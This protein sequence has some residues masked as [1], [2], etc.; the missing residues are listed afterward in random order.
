MTEVD[1]FPSFSDLQNT[2]SSKR[3]GESLQGSRQPTTQRSFARA[4]SLARTLTA[5]LLKEDNCQRRMPKQTRRAKR[6]HSSKPAAA[7]A[8]QT[9]P[10]PAV[11]NVLHGIAEGGQIS[12]KERIRISEM[13][14]NK[15]RLDGRDAKILLKWLIPNT[16]L[17]PVVSPKASA[18]TPRRSVS[19]SDDRTPTSESRPRRLSQRSR[20]DSPKLPWSGG[21]RQHGADGEDPMV[22]HT[23]WN[24]LFYNL[25]RSVDELYCMCETEESIDESHEAIRVLE[26][27]AEDF[28]ALIRRFHVER[29][30]DAAPPGIQPSGVAWELRKMLSPGTP[31][32]P[33]PS[34]PP[35]PNSSSKR[36]LS[37]GTPPLPSPS[38]RPSPSKLELRPAE[39][40]AAE[41]SGSD[42]GWVVA[43]SRNRRRAG[44]SD[45]PKSGRQQA[46]SPKRR[47]G[48]S[49]AR[50]P[51][52]IDTSRM[53]SPAEDSFNAHV[54]RI[55]RMSNASE[56]SYES[57]GS[58]GRSPSDDEPRTWADV[59]NVRGAL[60]NR[61]IHQRLS[62]Q[63]R[64]SPSKKSTLEER[65]AKV[66]ATLVHGMGGRAACGVQAQQRRKQQQAERDL[67]LRQ[68]NEHALQVMRCWCSVV[69]LS[70][71]L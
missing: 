3:A 20:K 68:Q 14:E 26:Q 52:T 23:L 48:A 58:L 27:C 13:L 38:P 51:P 70:V 43:R 59:C 2:N 55:R 10:G 9:E 71:A 60:R 44:A 1:W 7:P 35:L 21:S 17:S 25:N 4:P 24:Y 45:A 33:T 49:T 22:K 50:Q 19:P 53:A 32:L 56:N 41:H 62:S 67:R 12:E 46:S 64:G 42:D 8:E 5:C 18:K 6:D 65:H 28:K 34:S 36:M 11:K 61:E 39:I 31:P 54:N 47:S 37:P 57:D 66:L 40:A 63:E 30:M 69:E 29:H 16:Q 15:V